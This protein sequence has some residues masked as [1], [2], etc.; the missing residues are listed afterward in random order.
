ML[1]WNPSTGFKI[2]DKL[3][4]ETLH[5][6]IRSMPQHLL[7]VLRRECQDYKIYKITKSFAEPSFYWNAFTGLKCRDKVT[8]EII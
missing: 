8:N 4:P 6:L 1:M 5:S 2:W 7:C 3:I